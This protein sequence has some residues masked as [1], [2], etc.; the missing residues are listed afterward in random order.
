MITQQLLKHGQGL[1]KRFGAGKVLLSLAL[2]CL[3]PVALV[4]FCCCGLLLLF[5]DWM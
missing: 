4:G 5:A 1:A 3:V 2:G